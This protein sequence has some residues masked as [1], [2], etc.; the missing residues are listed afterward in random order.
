MKKINALKAVLGA[1]LCSL[2]ISKPSVAQEILLIDQQSH[3]V[4]F[5]QDNEK[6]I[7]AH[8]Y[9][10]LLS[11]YVL[12]EALESQNAPIFTK[13][14]KLDTQPYLR[15]VV[16]AVNNHNDDALLALAKKLGWSK[17]QFDTLL[18]ETLQ[19]LGMKHTTLTS[20]QQTT[21]T[22]QSKLL[23]QIVVR[24][25]ALLSPINNL[26]ERLSSQEKLPFLGQLSNIT[27]WMT[28][29]EKSQGHWAGLFWIQPKLRA[30][31]NSLL[32]L[33]EDEGK[34]AF[35]SVV[36]QSIQKAVY[37]YETFKLYHSGQTITHSQLY[38]GQ[39]DSVPVVTHNDIWITV[40]KEDFITEGKD[41][42]TIEF[43][44]MSPILAPIEQGE[45]I[46]SLLIYYDHKLLNQTPLYAGQTI[47]RGGDLRQLI[48]T[49]KLIF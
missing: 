33:H 5:A 8:P 36:K 30:S 38:M 35:Q 20:P 40:P 41:K 28:P 3:Q 42:L 45:Y 46:G 25:P 1:L 37:D 18:T 6:V 10:S 44:Q 9:L 7:P 49:F 11:G 16:E 21:L 15:K 14:S 17:E 43:K 48:D 27:G 19:T 13:A 24:A 4:L 29:V 31:G 2:I 23:S 47:E 22:D 26:K 32:I 34:Q 39:E 12:Y